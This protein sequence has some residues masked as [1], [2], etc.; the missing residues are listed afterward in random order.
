MTKIEMTKTTKFLAAYQAYLA[1]FGALE[2]SN[3]GIRISNL[4]SDTQLLTG[5]AYH[6]RTSKVV[7]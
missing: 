7:G 4:F 6:D 5:R 2:H 3:F 1:L